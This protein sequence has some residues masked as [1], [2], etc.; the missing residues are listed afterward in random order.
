MAATQHILPGVIHGRC[1]CGVLNYTLAWPFTSAPTLRACGCDYCS[2]HGALWTSDPKA[3]VTLAI[4][5]ATL[6]LPYRFATA[7]ADFLVCRRC[8]VL[9]LARCALADGERCVINANTFENLGIEHCGRVATDFDGEDREQRLA[10]R[11]RNW[12]PL[13][14][15]SP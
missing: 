9:T 14:V 4:V 5:D 6:V 10:R 3:V 7:S 12:S 15:T 1:H 11:Q 8:G 2:R 13:T